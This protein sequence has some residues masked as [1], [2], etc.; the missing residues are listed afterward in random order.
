MKGKRDAVHFGVI[1]AR[2]RGSMRGGSKET[3]RHGQG[4]LLQ[5]ILLGLEGQRV[6]PLIVLYRAG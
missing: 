1:Q 2:D 4:P 3:N 5:K 6:V